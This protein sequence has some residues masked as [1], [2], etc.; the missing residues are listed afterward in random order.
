[1]DIVLESVCA[2]SETVVQEEMTFKQISERPEDKGE[3]C[4]WQWKS[5]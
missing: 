3:I 1:M 4:S 2:A 5:R